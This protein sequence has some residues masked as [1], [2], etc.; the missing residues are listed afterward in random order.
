[1]AEFTKRAIDYS[2]EDLGSVEKNI[3]SLAQKYIVPIDNIR[4][5]ARPNTNSPTSKDSPLK[6][7]NI[8]PSSVQESRAHAFYRMLGFPIATSNNKFYCP[9]YNPASSGDNTN[10]EEVNRKFYENKALVNLI[11]SRETLYQQISKKFLLQDLGCSLYALVLRFPSPFLSMKEDSDPFT[12]DEQSG[13]VD[14]R[15]ADINRFIKRNPILTNSIK[16]EKTAMGLAIKAVGSDFGGFQHILKPFIVDPR[17]EESVMPLTNRICVPFAKNIYDTKINQ[18]TILQRPGI[19][20][21]LRIRL[22]NNIEDELFLKNAEKT[23]TNSNLPATDEFD[24]KTAIETIEA[25]A[26]SLNISVSEMLSGI[27]SIQVFIISQLTK[28][29]KA[30]ILELYNSI[31]NIDSAIKELNW[32]PYPSI[33]GPELGSSGGAKVNNEGTS[34][35]SE[36]ELKIKEITI[37]KDLAI[38]K[39]VDLNDLGKFASPFSVNLAISEDIKKYDDDLEYLVSKRD[40]VGAEAL[41]SMGKIAL[42]TGE[43]SGLGLIDI[44]SIYIALWSLDEKSLL[45]FLDHEAFLRLYKY[46][47]QLITQEVQNRYNGSE[48]DISTTL[49]KFEKQLINVLKF[50]DNEFK[51]LLENPQKIGGTIK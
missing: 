16:E 6:S 17:I 49:S 13:K 3:I 12:I 33:R 46:N 21:I 14:E 9:G 28:T 45:G 44:L 8:D 1:M 42:I 34:L 2:S 18:N 27:S 31:S 23:L 39:M 51:R 37:K 7:L 38:T 29:L 25:M 48:Q 43:T 5:I 22:L 11:N 50:A 41:D 20:A 15:V 35:Y 19:E 47:P 36:I 32:A 10:K 24:R 4:S 30:V 26:G 40:Q